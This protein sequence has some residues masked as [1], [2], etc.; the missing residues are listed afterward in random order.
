MKKISKNKKLEKNHTWIVCDRT[1]ELWD[2]IDLLSEEDLIVSS[3][4]NGSA[5]EMSNESAITDLL[6][7]DISSESS[8]SQ[9]FCLLIAWRSSEA[10][11]N[12]DATAIEISSGFDVEIEESCSRP[13]KPNSS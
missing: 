2:I 4:V 6:E 9:S 8:F 13:F 1:V 10:M 5:S 12:G 3:S 11:V 7:I